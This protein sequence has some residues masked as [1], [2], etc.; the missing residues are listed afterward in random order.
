MLA[1]GNGPPVT[2]TLPAPMIARQ[3]RLDRA[4][5]GGEGNRR[6]RAGRAAAP[7]CVSVNVPPV[8]L[9]RIESVW[10]AELIESDRGTVRRTVRLRYI[11][12]SKSDG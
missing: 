12:R 1:L 5:V 10:T 6:R 2:V 3:S 9:P 4:G 8:G 11:H 7:K